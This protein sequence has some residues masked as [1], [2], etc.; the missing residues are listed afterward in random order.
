M[1]LFT[2]PDNPRTTVSADSSSS[3]SSSSRRDSASFPIMH[4]QI[5]FLAASVGHGSWLAVFLAPSMSVSAVITAFHTASPDQKCVSRTQCPISHP[6]RA[7]M[8]P[9]SAC[10]QSIHGVRAHSE[11]GLRVVGR[12]SAVPRVGG[13]PHD[14]P[15]AARIRAAHAAQG[16]VW[17]HAA[18]GYRGEPFRRRLRTGPAARPHACEARL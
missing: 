1:V 16:S 5:L 11:E 15:A 9:P 7:R 14:A 18:R 3:A 2:A 4:T 13:P 17:A 6:A 12:V 8:R 10:V